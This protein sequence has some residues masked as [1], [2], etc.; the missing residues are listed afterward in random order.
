MVEIGNKLV[1]ASLLE[2]RFVCDLNAC[3]GACCVEGD[4]GAPV[5]LAEISMLE[6]I[7]EKVK[8]YMT[9]KGIEAV[10]NTGVFYMDEDN[11]PVTTLMDGGACAFTVFEEDGT[12]KCGIEKA[13]YDK[14]IKW[15]KPLS[16]ELFPIRVKEYTQ[17]TAVNF[18]EIDICKPACS[19]GEKL[20]IPVYRFL[21][22]PI[23]RGFGE[24]F[25]NELVE[26]EKLLSNEKD[27]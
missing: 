27:E 24:E 1:S 17:F 20:N 3:K 4:A 7:L 22:A 26:A 2:R 10:E 16:C 9:E 25:F 8:P 18:E 15:K 13:Y 14:E 5:T 12:A 19:C 11:D 21:K 23:I 6:S